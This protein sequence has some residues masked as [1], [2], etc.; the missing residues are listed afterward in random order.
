MDELSIFARS[1][2]PSPRR[3]IS[4]GGHGS[5]T[6]HRQ[7]TSRFAPP[8]HPGMVRR[9]DTHELQLDGSEGEGGGQIL[10]SALTLS[11]L[12]GRPFRIEQIRANRSKPG[13]RP[14]HLAAVR[15]AAL[16]GHATVEGDQLGSQ[17]LRFS[18][19]TYEPTDLTLDIGTAG[20]TALVLHTLHLAIAT[21]ALS[22]IHVRLTG[23]TF[24]DHAPS[25]PFLQETWRSYQEQMGM[26]LALSMPRAGFYPR[27]GGQLEAWI[28]P[29][30]PRP[31]QLLE[32]GP[33]C[34]IKASA[35]ALNLSRSHVA[36]R[37]LDQ[38]GVRLAEQGLAE[39]ASFAVEDWAGTGQGAAI[40]LTAEFGAT[41]H[42]GATST[43]FVCLGAPGKPAE[44]VADDA[45]DE[46]LEFLN[47]PGA[48][49]AHSAD[50]MLLPLCLAPG[51]STF[52][53]P[54]VTNHLRTNAGTVMAF[55]DR[56]IRIRTGSEPGQPATLEIA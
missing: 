11:L 45:I 34:G 37:L 19:T 56:T 35:G 53:T 26:R 6:P 27:G 12:T 8:A 31:L 22:P 3:W 21:R 20:G 38:A 10:R 54:T 41:Q 47:Q 55:L 33:L 50:Q 9:M 7:P 1:G 40:S 52:T 46:L 44:A 42:H 17:T 30:Q 14:Q 2:A 4:H 36:Q 18:P 39:L 29:G 51:V 24:N 25:F 16:L 23:G 13:L 32:R 49:D 28:E 15:A 48:V 43:T 5:A